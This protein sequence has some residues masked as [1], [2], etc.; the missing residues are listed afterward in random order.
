MSRTRRA[1][2]GAILVAVPLVAGGFVWQSREARDGAV[3]F[4][5]V[6]QRVSARFVDTVDATALY[7]KAARGLI[8]QLNDPYTTL[9]TPKEFAAFTQGTNGRYAGVG[10]QIE[11]I[12]G[13]ITV[14]K[15][16][17]NSPAAGAG[18][19]EGDRI[20]MIDSASTRGWIVDSVSSKLKGEPGTKV[21]VRFARPGVPEPINT[22]FTRATIHIP[23]VP[24]VTMLDGGVG[25]LPVQGF[26]ETASAETIRGIQQLQREG[27][28]SLILDLRGNPGGILDEAFVMSNLFLP[29]GKEILSYRGRADM[30]QVFIAQEDPMVPNLPVVVLVDDGTASASEIVAGALQDHDRA[31]I[32]GTTSFGKGLVQSLFRLDGGYALKMTTAKWFTPSGRSIQRPRKF[33][34]GRFVEEEAP[35]SMETDSAKKA[36]PA[37]K[38][39]AGRVIYGGGGIAPDVTVRPDT[40]TTI[41]QK[42]ARAMA[43]RFQEAYS[44]LSQFAEELRPQIKSPNF[45]VTDAWRAEYFRRI[46]AAK[47][48]VDSATYFAAPG[49]FNRLIGT[50]VARSVYGDSTAAKRQFSEDPQ[51]KKALELLRR[52]G[53]QRDLLSMAAPTTS[54]AATRRP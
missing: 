23:A 46:N 40:L 41:E 42:A 1:V 10:M 26:N 39:D 12:K 44:T 18:I 15:V 51:I 33:A 3:L 4:D 31:L 7:E 28:K 27:M 49:Y 35:D 45:T 19:S 50:R 9:Y 2:V 53:T 13:S 32:I 11:D 43:P 20:V 34:N 29:K 24:F 21:R 22:V 6:L 16:F 30:N 5:Q 36:R 48:P 47:V 8:A 52:G 17:P 54:A 38:S 37:F 14:V 25:Y